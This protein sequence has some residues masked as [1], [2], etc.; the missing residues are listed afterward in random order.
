MVQTSG[1]KQGLTQSEVYRGITRAG[2]PHPKM[3]M[4]TARKLA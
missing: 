2:I 4:G 3:S 1:V